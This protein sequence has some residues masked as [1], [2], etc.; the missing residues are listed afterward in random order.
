MSTLILK[1]LN[2]E[3]P[4]WLM[5]QA[6]RYLKEYKLVRKKQKNFINFCLN[7]FSNPGIK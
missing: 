1:A 4:I 7:N 5:R 3:K 2:K 6:G